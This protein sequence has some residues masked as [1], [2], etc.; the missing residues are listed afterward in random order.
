MKC[1]FVLQR[2]YRVMYNRELWIDIAWCLALAIVI[3]AFVW[4]VAGSV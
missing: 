4:V 2:G 3:F 1:G